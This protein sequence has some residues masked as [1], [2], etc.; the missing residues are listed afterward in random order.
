MRGFGPSG[1]EEGEEGLSFYFLFP[2]FQSHFQNR[3][4]NHFE[5]CLNFNKTTQKN[6]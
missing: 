5:L 2:L 4:K 1:Q 6:N 3:F